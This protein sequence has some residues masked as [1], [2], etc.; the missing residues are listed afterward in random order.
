MK[1]KTF[2]IVIVVWLVVLTLLTTLNS[3]RLKWLEAQYDNVIT[4][5]I[6]R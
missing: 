6:E 2:K 5:L 3:Q 4:T 1:K